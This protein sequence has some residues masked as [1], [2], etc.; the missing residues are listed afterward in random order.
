MVTAAEPEPQV[1]APEG[2]QVGVDPQVL[3]FGRQRGAFDERGAVLEHRDV[4]G[5]VD[6]LGHHQRQPVTV[7][8]EVRADAASGERLPPV[9]DVALGE[10]VAARLEDLLADEVGP[11]VEQAH[12]ILELVAEAERSA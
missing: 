2:A 7:V 3:G 8:G 11:Y 6:V 10:L 12:D 9:Q 5:R 4:A 1:P